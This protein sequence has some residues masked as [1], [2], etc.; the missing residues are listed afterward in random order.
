MPET[1]R[2]RK[3]VLVASAVDSSAKLHWIGVPFAAP[4][5]LLAW[6]MRLFSPL[7]HPLNRPSRTNFAKYDFA[8]MIVPFAKPSN[9]TS[10]TIYAVPAGVPVTRLWY[11][12]ALSLIDSRTFTRA[13]GPVEAEG[14]PSPALAGEE[15]AIFGVASECDARAV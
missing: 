14:L 1:P 13:P 6:E 4:S 11:A 15:L 2:S 7:N 10:L 12:A 8:S 9:F 3:R 5:C